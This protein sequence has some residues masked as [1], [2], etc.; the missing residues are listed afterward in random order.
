[1][2]AIPGTLTGELA[3]RRTPLREWFAEQL[4]HCGS[5][6]EDFRKSVTQEC[7]EPPKNVPSGTI[8]AALDY[9]IRY[10]LEPKYDAPLAVL[11]AHYAQLESGAHTEATGPGWSSVVQA[12]VRF[13]QKYVQGVISGR[14]NDPEL[15]IALMRRC[16]VLA[17]FTEL[18]RGVP[19]GRSPLGRLVTGTS[20][21]VWGDFSEVMPDE[22]GGDIQSLYLHVQGTLMP[23]IEARTYKGAEVMGP[24]LGFPYLAAD[25]DLIVGTTLV[26]VKAVVGRR[27]RT[28]APRYGLDAR[29]L[30]QVVGYALL[31]V[32]AGHKID[33]VAIFN[34]RYAHLQTWYLTPLL[35]EL[36]GR[37]ICAEGFAMQ[38]RSFIE[39]KYG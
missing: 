5:V 35:S 8:G 23:F 20:A 32:I 27:T 16:W 6:Y 13:L 1:M 37:P 36:A 28:G 19:F 14:R 25:A 10:M 12:A 33:E 24:N 34:A 11:G 29:L 26:E 7:I 15:L 22:V 2:S 38:F 17:L 3:R 39:E 4:P 31:G 21:R 9:L 18:V 30:Y